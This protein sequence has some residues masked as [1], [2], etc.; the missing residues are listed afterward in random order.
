MT[1]ALLVIDVQVDFCE[2]GAL[3]CAGG[4]VTAKRI[5]E[6]LESNKGAYDYVIASRDWHKANDA[7][8]GHFAEKT[9][10]PISKPAGR[11]TVLKMNWEA[12]TTRT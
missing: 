1:K 4:A 7:N 11:N 9:N 2:G 8:G 6:H 12:S 10:L 5:T 3:A